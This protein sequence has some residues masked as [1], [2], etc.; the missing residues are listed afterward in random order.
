MPCTNTCFGAGAIGENA[1][2]VKI[3]NM[4]EISAGIIIYRITAQGPKFLLLYHGNNYWNFPKGK[5]E[6][7]ERSFQAALREIKEETGLVRGDLN[8][9]DYFKTKENFYF[10]RKIGEKKMKV[11]KNITFYLAET[12]KKQIKISEKKEGEPHEG[13]AWVTFPEAMKVLTK[14]KDSRRILTQ[15]Y[16]FLRKSKS[17]HAPSDRID[18]GKP[19]M[20]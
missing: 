17:S 15:A 6:V 14:N 8:F 10:Y 20:V 11:F 12:Q 3:K 7:A 19:K 5:L 16:N 4:R 18:T 13:F 9:S 1:K 2:N